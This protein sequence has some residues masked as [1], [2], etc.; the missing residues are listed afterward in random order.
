[1]VS[2]ALEAGEAG[3]FVLRG[4]QGVEELGGGGG[5]Q[6]A[7]QSCLQVCCGAGF[8]EPVVFGKPGAQLSLGLEESEVPG[9]LPF[10]HPVGGG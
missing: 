2:F 5:A 3:H 9:S 4:V 6:G 8:G 10:W 7:G 1:M